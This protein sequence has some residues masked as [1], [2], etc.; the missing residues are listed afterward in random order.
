MS[1]KHSCFSKLKSAISSTSK[2]INSVTSIAS[3]A[4]TGNETIQ[5]STTNVVLVLAKTKATDVPSRQDIAG[6]QVDIGDSCQMLGLSSTECASSS[7]ISQVKF[8]L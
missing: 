3:Q 1:D 8:N 4:L 6:C 5:I 7:I 2:V